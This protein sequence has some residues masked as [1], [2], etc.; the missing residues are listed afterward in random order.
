[1][2]A[3]ISIAI[4][5]ILKAIDISYENDSF[6]FKET[7]NLEKF[8]ISEKRF[9]AILVDLIKEGYIDGFAFEPLNPLLK[10]VTLKTKEPSVFVAF[11]PR[12]T[13]KGMT[14]LEENTTMK[15]VYNFLKETKSWFPG[16]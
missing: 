5:R 10:K 13:L 1:M 7:F 8:N 4:F 15:K 3:P 2:N 6:S 14:Y 9:N 11:S 16:G 12:L